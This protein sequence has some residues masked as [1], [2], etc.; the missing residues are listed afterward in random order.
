MKSKLF[1]AMLIPLSTAV[2]RADI[3]KCTAT[4]AGKA[5]DLVVFIQRD[6]S[7]GTL[8]SRPSDD[9][10]L[11]RKTSGA[12]GET[13]GHFKTTGPAGEAGAVTEVGY[14]VD[15]GVRLFVSKAVERDQD[16][17][18]RVVMGRELRAIDD[19]H[20]YWPQSS[21]FQTAP[22]FYTQIRA[23]VSSKSKEY[24]QSLEKADAAPVGEG[25]DN[26]EPTSYSLSCSKVGAREFAPT[27][28]L[29]AQGNFINLE[30]IHDWALAHTN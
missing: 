22:Q 30:D 5:K 25:K 16:K 14:D 7:T 11:T 23:D 3:V 9:V 20:I 17:A 4:L 21:D 12:Q 15:E 6:G 18:S 29:D 13:L 10:V 19:I 26:D 1:I 27:D 28:K 2:A 8:A 24:S